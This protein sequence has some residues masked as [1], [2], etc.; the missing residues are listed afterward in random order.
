MITVKTGDLL[1]SPSHALVNTVNCVGIMGKGV[2]LAFKKR[3]P[4]MFKDYVQRCQRGEVRLGHPYTYATDDGHVVVNFPTKDHWR[5][6][7]RLSDILLGLDSLK[8]HYQEWG[9]RSIAVPP[10]GCGNGQLEWRVIGPTLHRE[11]SKLAIPVELYA[12]LGTPAEQM[13]LDFFTEPTVALPESPESSFIEPSWVA[14]VEV[15]RRIEQ[16]QYRWPV[17]RVRFQKIAYFLTAEGLPTALEYRRDSYG[18]YAPNLKPVASR[19]INNGLVTEQRL[20]Q[21]IEMRS[22]PTYEDARNAFKDALAGWS[23]EI[24]KVVDL[25]ARMPTD[26][27]EVAATVHFAATELR[28][29]RDRPPTEQEVLDEVKQ[30]KAR[31]RPPMAETDII[32]ATEQLAL[33]RWI[34]VLPSPELHDDADEDLFVG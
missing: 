25:F 1:K 10:L 26:H 21:M 24:D 11:L 19:L 2:A 16:R 22:G 8:E 33:L 5:A 17:G 34:E 9:I 29:R 6:V 20:G 23:R 31:R 28:N 27:A 18:P 12:P 3:Y 13:Q 15:L 32:A 4:E 30:W 14:L 7:S